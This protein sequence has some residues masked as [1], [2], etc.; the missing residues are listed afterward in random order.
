M[1]SVLQ[2]LLWYF[3]LLSDFWEVPGEPT[4]AL[5]LSLVLQSLLFLD[6]VLNVAPSAGAHFQVCCN[7]FL[8]F[9]AFSVILLGGWWV[10][11][12]LEMPVKLT[13]A[14]RY[15]SAKKAFGSICYVAMLPSGV[16]H[17]NL[18]HWT[19]CNFEIARAWIHKY[20]QSLLKT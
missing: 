11:P 8:P 3:S 5:L 20:G 18:W 13:A 4:P 19:S 10:H 6:S 9:V 15:G 16:C 17:M 14:C 2:L 7:L 12:H 1:V